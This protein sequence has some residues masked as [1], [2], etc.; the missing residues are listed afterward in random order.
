MAK[1]IDQELSEEERFVLD[2]M[3]SEGT[4][5]LFDN[6]LQWLINEARQKLWTIHPGPGISFNEWAEYRIDPAGFEY[7]ND[8]TGNS[9]M[10]EDLLLTA[11]DVILKRIMKK[12]S[13]SR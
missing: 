13:E 5:V 9:D 3:D 4:R 10:Y 8:D 6:Y 1:K 11:R 2:A 12:Y 7:L